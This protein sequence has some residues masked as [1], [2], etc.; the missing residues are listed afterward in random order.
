ML[1]F[2][3]AGRLDPLLQALQLVQE[4]IVQSGRR[5]ACQRVDRRAV[6]E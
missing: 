4:G 5:A 2:Q 6:G 3:F 1:A